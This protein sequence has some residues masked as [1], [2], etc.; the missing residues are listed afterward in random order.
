MRQPILGQLIT[1]DC[2]KEKEIEI[3]ISKAWGKYWAL[4]SIF[5][6]PFSPDQKSEIFNMC[7][8]PTLTYG[9]QTWRLNEKII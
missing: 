9:Y 5:K 7:V 1:L 2:E 8:L 3:R 6:G 4:G